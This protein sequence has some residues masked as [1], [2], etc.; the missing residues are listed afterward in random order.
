MK[1]INILKKE[2]ESIKNNK[3]TE[4]ILK[5]ELNN[6]DKVILK[7][8][9]KKLEV[10]IT[11]TAKYSSIEECLKIIPIELFGD[12]TKEKLLSKYKN[13]ISVYRIKYDS[14][15]IEEIDNQELLDLI[16]V[17]TL[18]KNNIG[19]SSINV[20]EVECKNNK[21]AILKIQSLFS[22]NDLYEEYLRI[23]WLQNKLNVPKIYY[24]K[25]LNNKKYLLMEKKTGIPAYKTNSFYDIGKTLK[26]IHSLPINNCPFKQNSIDNLLENALK[27][28]DTIY[29]QVK[30]LYPNMSKNDV[31]E[32]LNNKK[33]TDQV[34]VHGDYSLPNILLDEDNNISLIDLGDVSISSIY[35]DL[36]YLR[37]SMIRNKKM[38][39]FDELLAGY[40]IKEL[41]EDYMKWIEIIDKA[42]V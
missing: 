40:G 27:N 10:E 32:F 16:K 34:L 24:Y 2:L 6:K 26:Q 21:Q 18:K 31:I 42:L 36:F 12:T 41:N 11:G 14:E 19:H 4:I 1:E 7:Y 35:F 17:D 3:Q 5:E 23:E 15:E 8:K 30:E 9:D 38:E 13:N 29:P 25:E 22:R 33:P 20:Y 28:I 39:Y 37:K